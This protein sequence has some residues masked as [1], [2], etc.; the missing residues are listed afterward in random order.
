M[1]TPFTDVV[2][3]ADRNISISNSFPVTKRGPGITD[4]HALPPPANPPRDGKV[5]ERSMSRLGLPRVPG[6]ASNEMD[7][8]DYYRDVSRIH[9]DQTAPHYVL[10]DMTAGVIEALKRLNEFKVMLTNTTNAPR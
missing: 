4:T 5:S 7:T 6:V 9:K 8:S 10:F 2:P 1:S 3:S